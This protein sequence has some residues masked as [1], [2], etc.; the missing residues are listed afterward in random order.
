ME[1][2]KG[3][4]QEHEDLNVLVRDLSKVSRWDATLLLEEPVSRR[5]RADL[6]SIC[7]QLQRHFETEEAGHYLEEIGHRNPEARDELKSL[8]DEHP[9]LMAR[10][11]KAREHFESALHQA[12]EVFQEL[13]L[14]A[15][16]LLRRHEARETALV[17]KVFGG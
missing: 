10:F 4:L 16:Q 5:L 17:K 11:Q 6:H 9:R 3:V 1:S 14:E 2:A 12:P 8:H 13:L 7:V 15:I